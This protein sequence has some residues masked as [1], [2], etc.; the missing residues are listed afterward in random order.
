[1]L[2]PAVFAVLCAALFSTGCNRQGEQPKKEVDV[3]VEKPAA[4]APAAV[5][6]RPPADPAKVLVTIGDKTLTEG[7]LAKQADEQ[8]EQVSAMVPPEQIETYRSQ[9]R[10]QAA[11]SFIVSTLLEGEASKRGLTVTDTDIE[12]A[13]A[14]ITKRLPPDMTLDKVLEMEDMTQDTFKERLKKDLRIKKLF[15][16]EMEKTGAITDK[17]VADFYASQK[18]AFEVPEQVTARHILVKTDE[19]DDDA[20]KAA[21][22]AKIE[23]LR[24]QLLAGADFAKLAT[25]NSDCPSAKDGGMLGKF[26]RGQ[27]VPAFETA[28]FTQETNAIGPV[29]DTQFGYHIVQVIEKNPGETRDL[30]EVKAQILDYLKMMKSRKVIPPFIEKLREEAKITVDPELDKEIKAAQLEESKQAMMAAQEEG[31][32]IEEAAGE[33]EVTAPPAPAPAAEAPAAAP[34]APAAEVPASAPAAAPAAAPAK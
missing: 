17:E 15:D 29:V 27:M 28:A 22:K 21:K 20:A 3:S 24:K 1:M 23:D 16:Q 18:G 14:D 31:E 32:E 19:K 33:V 11:Q 4:S 6:A 26:G 8:F 13:I 9:M 12:K 2:R 25:E 7:D 34:A 30:E 5:K 10:V